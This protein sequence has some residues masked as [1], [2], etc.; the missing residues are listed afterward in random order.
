MAPGSGHHRNETYAV[1]RA[2]SEILE[3]PIKLPVAGQVSE[4]SVCHVTADRLAFHFLSTLSYRDQF[5]R[6]AP[7]SRTSHWI[8]FARDNSDKSTCPAPLCPALLALMQPLS[9]Q[10]ATVALAVEVIAARYA[11]VSWVG[12]SCCDGQVKLGVGAPKHVRAAVAAVAHRTLLALGTVKM[13]LAVKAFSVPCMT[14][15]TSTISMTQWQARQ[16]ADKR[17][18]HGKSDKDQYNKGDA[19][20]DAAC[21]VHARLTTIA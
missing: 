12:L 15:M 10:G 9:A 4:Y 3:H 14:S 7:H 19:G 2:L 8:K 17:D 18:K 5:T 16:W 1:D 11:S 20:D 13:G 21:G 6:P